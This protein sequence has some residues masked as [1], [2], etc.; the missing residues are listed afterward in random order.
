MISNPL[1]RP[2]T[3]T[4]PQFLKHQT[5]FRGVIIYYYI[6]ELLN[7]EHLQEQRQVARVCSLGNLLLNDSLWVDQLAS[8]WCVGV[9][10]PGPV[11]WEAGFHVP[12]GLPD[13]GCPCHFC[14]HYQTGDTCQTAPSL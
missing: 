6:D 2:L 7:S 4:P 13:P 8:L 12:L 11:L 10:V 3:P 1:P 9:G 14:P 5:G